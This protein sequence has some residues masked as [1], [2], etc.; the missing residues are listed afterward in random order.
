MNKG[1]YTSASGRWSTPGQL[2][3]HLDHEFAFDLDPC[4]G[5]VPLGPGIR[6][7]EDGLHEDWF[8]F[9]TAFVNPP[10]GRE[11]PLWLKRVEI[12]LWESVAIR[13]QLKGASHDWNPT[14]VLTKDGWILAPE[15]QAVLLIPARTDTNWWHDFVLPRATEIRFLRGRLG[16]EGIPVKPERDR[17]KQRSRAPF[18]SVVVLV[19]PPSSAYLALPR[20]VL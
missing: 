19:K 9:R 20:D 5:K 10:Y 13:N 2:F 11:L 15:P 8:P 17:I 1:L 16:F 18:P 12:Q 7:L 6:G 3:N 14:H 4:P